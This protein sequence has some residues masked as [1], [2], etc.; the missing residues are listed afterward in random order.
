MRMLSVIM[1]IFLLFK[2]SSFSVKAFA[3]TTQKKYLQEGEC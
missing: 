1:I 2:T 3:E